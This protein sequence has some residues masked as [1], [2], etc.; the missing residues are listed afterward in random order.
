MHMRNYLRIEP[1]MHVRYV[2]YILSCRPPIGR[3]SRD[4]EMFV[5]KGLLVLEN[6]ANSPTARDYTSGLASGSSC[7]LPSS[8][9]DTR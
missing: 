3:F 7:I 4:C 9:I 6:V 5:M 1:S 8:Y 2:V